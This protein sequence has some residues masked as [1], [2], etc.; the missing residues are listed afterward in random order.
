MNILLTTG[1]THAP[2]D[3]VRV[4]T[5]VFPGRTGA[6]LARTLWVRGHRITVL[7]SQ[8]WTLS[9]LPDPGQD[10]D[11]RATVVP[12][13]TYDDLTTLLQKEVRGGK[14][15]MTDHKGGKLPIVEPEVWVRLVRAP[16][17]IDRFR[18]PWGF[19]GVL[20][21]FKQEIGIGDPELVQAAEAS[22]LRCGADLAVATTREGVA[23]YAYVG[24]LQER[25]DRVDR[26]ELADRLAVLVEDAHKDRLRAV[27]LEAADG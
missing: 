8:P 17:L 25:Y 11:R 7:T 22:R 14:P 15:A 3:R 23:H 1:N 19:R 16:K 10:T 20:V 13:Q 18:N 4:I 2:I 6:E 5:N 12:F 9:D 21:E 27:P 26:R 24:P